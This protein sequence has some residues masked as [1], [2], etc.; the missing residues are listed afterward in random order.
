MRRDIESI[1]DIINPDIALGAGMRNP[2]TFS[3]G[4]LLEEARSQFH[5]WSISP[6]DLTEPVS[7]L[8]AL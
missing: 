1:Y 4:I 2:K 6:S 8:P 5:F 7:T 3:G